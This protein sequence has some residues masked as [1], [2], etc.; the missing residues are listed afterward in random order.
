L[1][2]VYA[3]SGGKLYVSSDGGKTFSQT[4]TLGSSTESRAIAVNTLGK[5]GELWISTN[6]GIW[7]SSDFGKTV[8]GLSGGLSSAYSIAVGAPATKNGTPALFAAGTVNNVGGLW[9]SDNGGTSWTRTLYSK[10]AVF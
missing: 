5:A 8:I 10:L 9:R 2:Q 3:T 7:H 4:V 6:R 1:N